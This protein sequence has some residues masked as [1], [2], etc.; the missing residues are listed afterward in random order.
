MAKLCERKTPHPA[1]L[2]PSASQP[3][4][5]SVMSDFI[6]LM[7]TSQNA[8]NG[9]KK[10]DVFEVCVWGGG[11]RCMV[12]WGFGHERVAGGVG[13]DAWPGATGPMDGVRSGLI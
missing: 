3:I 4:P 9:I 6:R 7:E 10:A 11:S 1:C 2:P 8:L 5:E 13:W 12:W